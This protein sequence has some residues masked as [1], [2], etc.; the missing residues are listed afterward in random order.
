VRD[1]GR[2]KGLTAKS[3]VRAGLVS[4]NH[5]ETLVHEKGT[6]KG[7]TV[8]TGVIAANAQE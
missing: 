5:N 6:A 8:K 3:R 2:A 1:V 4:F 7:L